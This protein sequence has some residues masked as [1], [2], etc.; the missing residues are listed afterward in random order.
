MSST[1]KSLVVTS[2]G[3]EQTHAVGQALARALTGGAVVSLE[4]PLGSGKTVL[5]R[6]ICEGLGVRGPV[7][8]P[9]YTLENEYEGEDGRLVVHMDCFRLA[10]ASDLEDLGVEERF[11]DAAV[12]LVEWGEKVIDALPPETLRIRF[13]P[14]G[15]SE[16]RIIVSIPE[17]VS[18]PGLEEGA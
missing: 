9:T 4:G 8:S 7:T 16:R 6:G 11:E 2:H 14:E 13:E 12:V 1:G 10:G 18:L 5:V 3:P 15:E 17:G